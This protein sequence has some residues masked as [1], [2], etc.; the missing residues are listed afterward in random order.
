MG[1]RRVRRAVFSGA[2]GFI[3][4]IGHNLFVASGSTMHILNMQGAIVEDAEIP[5][6]VL[7]D[8]FR[9]GDFV[10]L[11]M[12]CG[13]H[14]LRLGESAVH[15]LE[16]PVCVMKG[17]ASV[18]FATGNMLSILDAPGLSRCLATVP[19]DILDFAELRD[20]VYILLEAHVVCINPLDGKDAV[21]RPVE[22]LSH[23]EFVSMDS[24]GNETLV[25]E[26]V[27][28]LLVCRQTSF[29]AVKK[30]QG[31]RRHRVAGELLIVLSDEVELYVLAS[32]QRHA[33][34]RVSADLVSYDAHRMRLW[35]YSGCLYEVDV[36]SPF[37]P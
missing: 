15:R 8:V 10:L 2:V 20:G 34:F 17:G 35:M 19:E 31:Y 1:E 25:L 13:H 22:F 18:L 27:G 21:P 29:W 24:D 23:L 33:R 30:P 5:P 16:L 36:A 26:S 32:G 28:E 37:N 6:G 11:S 14:F 7:R 3:K 12:D 4:S 9:L